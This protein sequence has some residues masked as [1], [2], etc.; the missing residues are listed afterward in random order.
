MSVPACFVCRLNIGSEYLW[1][2]CSL[3]PNYLIKLSYFII[4]YRKYLNIRESWNV[5]TRACTSFQSRP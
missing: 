1:K 5:L 4:L 3:L 2:Y